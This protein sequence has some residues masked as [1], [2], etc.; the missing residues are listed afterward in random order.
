MTK[1]IEE[2]LSPEYVAAYADEALENR[3]PYLGEALFPTKKQVGLTLDWIKGSKG[4]PVVL[5]PAAFDTKAPIRDRQGLEDMSVKM[6]YFKD[7]HVVDEELRQKLLLYLQAKNPAFKT[8]VT[9]IYDD[10]KDLIEAALAQLERMR[11]QIITTGKIGISTPEADYDY[12][13]HHNDA[14]EETLAGDDKWDQ[15]ATANIFEDIARFKSAVTDVSGN[16]VTRAILNSTTAAKIARSEVV[17]KAMNP[18]GYANEYISSKKVLAFL[19]EEF[20]IQFIVYDKKF[21]DE[22]GLTKSYVPDGVVSFLPNGTIGNTW[23][24]TTPEEANKAALSKVADVSI[25]QTGIAITSAVS[26]DP[27]VA[28]TK[29]SMVAMPSAENIDS[30]FIATVF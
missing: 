22:A 14:L 2:L 25:V 30:V 9:R 3:I 7:S 28:Q 1:T 20:D 26:Y 29:A 27:V 4:L 15:A 13:F 5:R 23:F 19:Q 10:T 12:D 8:L 11:M 6:P 18:V 17:R 21:I 24:G 16:A